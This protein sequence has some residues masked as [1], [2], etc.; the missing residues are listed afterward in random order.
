MERKFTAVN[1]V[2]VMVMTLVSLALLW[3]CA[4]YV[5]AENGMPVSG[6]AA[7]EASGEEKEEAEKRLMKTIPLAAD[8]V[9]QVPKY[10]VEQNVTYMLDESSI[11]VEETERGSA[12]GANVVTV[13]RK[14]ENLPDNDL[15]R[16]E[17]TILHEGISC[18]LLSVVYQ[19]EEEDENGIPVR[20]SAACEYGGLKKYSTSYPS[21]WQMTAWY[22][23]CD[24]GTDTVSGNER[25]EYGFSRIPAEQKT[26]VPETI[27]GSGE[28][29]EN[30]EEEEIPSSKPAVKKIQIGQQPE[31]DEGKKALDIPIPSAAAAAGAGLTLPFII[32]FGVTTAPLFAQKSA[33][34][35]RYIG[36][37]RLKK[38]EG[39]YTAYLT[40]RLA[41]R[42]QIPVF[43]IRLP[44]RIWKRTKAC[45]LQIKCPDGKKIT[46]TAG[47]TVG[48][49]V[50]GE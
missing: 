20:Y 23:V 22:D 27:E 1:R 12:E 43:Q 31:E 44:G 34:G 36:R 25:V 21:A 5:H 15:E 16:I 6:E 40:R 26:S 2:S 38:R 37:I 10:I 47:K 8:T 14:V 3:K 4:L 17:K 35:Y 28:E 50:E 42:A 33:G 18:D 13:S 11:A 30:I 46:L 41:G 48:F 49:T 45:M 9:T 19:V 24:V 32:W 29:Q 39:I 7:G